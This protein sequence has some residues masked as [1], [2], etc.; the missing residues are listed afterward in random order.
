MNITTYR[1]NFLV[2]KEII[3][4]YNIQSKVDEHIKMYPQSKEGL[5]FYSEPLDVVYSS[6]QTSLKS[7]NKHQAFL[8]NIETWHE[9]N[10]GTPR[11][12]RQMNG[13]DE[14]N[15]FY[16]GRDEILCSNEY[17]LSDKPEYSKY[18]DK[19]ILLLGAGPTTTSVEWEKSNYDYLWTMNHF[20][21]NER[22]VNK[23]P[24]LVSPGNEVDFDEL[25]Q[26]LHS[27][28]ERNNC[29]II[30]QPNDV[31]KNITKFKSKFR[32][33]IGYF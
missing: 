16:W 15:N 7:H 2:T 25:N 22:I 10:Q 3:N 1:N 21:L 4:K 30:I 13:Q 14:G 17:F 9:G 6:F 27:F 26:K 19:S 23:K 29:D 11:I 24:D 28:L 32:K 31:R 12:Q 5:I 8:D 20:F 18:K 33:R